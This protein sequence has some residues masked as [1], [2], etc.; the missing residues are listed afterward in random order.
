MINKDYLYTQ[1]YQPTEAP[2][3]LAEGASFLYSLDAEERS[4]YCINTWCK[5]NPNI[6]SYQIEEMDEDTIRIN[7]Q[8]ISLHSS[9]AL[10]DILMQTGSS[11]LYI[12]VSAMSCRII[13]PILKASLGLNMKVYIVYV[14]PRLYDIPAFKYG[15]NQDL[16][17]TVE[18]VKPL[19]GFAKVI[20]HSEDAIFIFL[21]GFEGGRFSYLLQDQ[22]PEYDNV[23]PII[24]IPGYIL[25]YPFESY[26]GNH[27]GLMKTR[28]WQMVKYAE[29]NSIVDAYV[30]LKN[31]AR[32]NS[33]HDM[34][35]APIGTKPHAIA[36]ILYAMS[37]EEKVELLYDNP[38]RGLHRTSGVKQVQICCVSDLLH[39]TDTL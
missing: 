18:G 37:H 1:I 4:A 14:E 23:R 16:V 13:A 21:L 27:Y 32:E 22:Q 34:V 2:A 29:A 7:G 11:S 10:S 6:S 9:N 30:E 36:A 26:W 20:P 25:N 5:Q 38:K 39:A 33:G 35:I 15:F 31:I 3:I 8:I 19:P 12:D 24:G 17:D 28:G